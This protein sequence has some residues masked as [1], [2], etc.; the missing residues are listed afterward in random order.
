MRKAVGPASMFAVRHQVQRQPDPAATRNR[1]HFPTE[2]AALKVLYLA[3]R[4][5]IEPR[6][7]DV[8]LVAPHWKNA[9][10]AFALFFEDRISVQ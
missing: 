5:Q 8:N 10:N 3:V 1:G 7:R 9:L 2:Q 4:E 6:T